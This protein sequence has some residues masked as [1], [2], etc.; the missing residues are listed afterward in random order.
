MAV[1][2][3]ANII[4]VPRRNSLRSKEGKHLERYVATH[5]PAIGFFMIV[6]VDEIGKKIVEKYM[7]RKLDNW[8][9][10]KKELNNVK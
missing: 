2:R 8:N 10:I 6:V 4:V 7:G 9:I 1:N 5:F 3:W